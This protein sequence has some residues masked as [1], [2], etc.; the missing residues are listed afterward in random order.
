M[1]TGLAFLGSPESP[2]Y[3]D[4][5]ARLRWR[6]AVAAEHDVDVKPADPATSAFA[7]AQVWAVVRA[8]ASV[9]IGVFSFAEVPRGA[10][11][12]AGRVSGTLGSAAAH[13]LR[14]LEAA[15]WEAA[16]GSAPL[17]AFRLDG[18]GPR[19]GE[20]VDVFLGRLL[21]DDDA[22]AIRLP[23][24][25][26]MVPDDPSDRARPELCDRLPSGIRRLA[27]VGCG[28]GATGAALKSRDPELHVT[29]IE[30]DP[31]AAGRARPRLDRV[32]CADAA[33]ALS[34]L[35]GRSE[36]FD[37]F[38]F[39]DVLE[40]TADP[41]ALLSAARAAAARG[42]LLIASVPNA[43]HISVARDL[44]LGRFDPA[45][46][47]PRDAGHLRWF[48]RPFLA[49]ALEE[50]GWGV[51][52]IDGIQG[53]PAPDAAGFVESVAGLTGLEP[54]LLSVYQWI[55]VASV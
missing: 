4:L 35:A 17:V 34:D 23:G 54:S 14:E 20:S 44:V 26:A 49:E 24:F 21:A 38:L 31:A 47:G 50:A 51:S 32:I 18:C 30:R 6:R 5:F 27:D 15:P 55:A 3:G 52:S 40:H 11:A 19:A 8:P 43:G 46:S 12:V 13:T 16:T 33:A 7:A 10:A 42:A 41:V 36:R 37:A 28:S 48:T 1:K 25:A 53:A 45:P 2:G 29:G 9:P 22:A 39:G